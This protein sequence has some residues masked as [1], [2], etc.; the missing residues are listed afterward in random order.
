[1]AAFVLAFAC[2][3]APLLFP[4][5]LAV[6]DAILEYTVTLAQGLPAG[7]HTLTLTTDG[8]GKVPLQAIRIYGPAVAAPTTMVY[9][10]VKPPKE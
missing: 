6:K 3:S 9:D 7:K 5:A 1:M 2:L 4:D 10:T 8:A